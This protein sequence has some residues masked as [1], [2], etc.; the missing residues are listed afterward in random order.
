LGNG[1]IFYGTEISVGTTIDNLYSPTRMSQ[2][3]LKGR[4]INSTIIDSINFWQLS[5]D[6]SASPMPIVENCNLITNGG[7]GNEYSILP[8]NGGSVSNIQ[9][10]YTTANEPFFT[11]NGDSLITP[12][13]NLGLG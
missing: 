7:S 1:L 3:P 11:G 5:I 2:I 12:N 4:L 6:V 8:I 9:V 10:F 13:Y